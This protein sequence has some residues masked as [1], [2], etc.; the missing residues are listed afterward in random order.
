MSN[1]KRI[2]GVKKF[3]DGQMSPQQVHRALAW[4]G[5]KCDACGGPAAER[6]RVFAEYKEVLQRSPE[7]VLKLAAEHGVIAR[8]YARR[9]VVTLE[10]EGEIDRAA[11]WLTLSILLDDI[12][13]HRLDPDIAPTIH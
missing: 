7:F 8:D 4:G 5:R 3:M 2:N 9:A 11:F 6:I 10:A 13:M 12:M 1:E